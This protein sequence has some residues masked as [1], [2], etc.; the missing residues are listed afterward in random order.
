MLRYET[1]GRFGEHDDFANMC[2]LVT[3]DAASDVNGDM[4][5]INDGRRTNAEDLDDLFFWMDE[6]WDS[7]NRGR[8]C[9][10]ARIRTSWPFCGF[11]SNPAGVVRQ[12]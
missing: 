11:Q 2:V 12:Q 10:Y 6:K 4:V 7:L 9:R 5:I 3:L 8:K 1:L